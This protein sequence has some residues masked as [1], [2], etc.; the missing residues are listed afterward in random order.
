MPLSPEMREQLRRK[1]GTPEPKKAPSA[2]PKKE[3]R[4]AAPPPAAPPSL[5]VRSDIEEKIETESVVTTP[6]PVALRQKREAVAQGLFSRLGTGIDRAV[7]YEPEPVRDIRFDPKAREAQERM[8]GSLGED[9]VESFSAIPG[10]LASGVGGLGGQLAS[11]V[12]RPV[13]DVATAGKEAFQD[14]AQ[15]NQYESLS[16][17]ARDS[18]ILL[19]EQDIARMQEQLNRLREAQTPRDRGRFEE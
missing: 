11:A 5:P 2:A 13:A 9:I 16:P 17:R 4:S 6:D 1:Y 10:A 18:Q 14:F 15:S 3:T 19:L 8:R 7:A 12:G